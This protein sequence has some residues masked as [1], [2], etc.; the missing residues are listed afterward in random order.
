[1]R[2]PLVVGVVGE[3]MLAFAA[4]FGPPLVLALI[5]GEWNSVRGFAVAMG[6]GL[7]CGTAAHR[8]V[9]AEQ[10]LNLHR[11]EAFAVVSMSWLLISALGAVPFVFDGMSWV[12]AWFESMSGFTT[13]GATVVTDFGA[14]DR[15]FYLWRAMEQ[16]FGGLGVIAL[17]VVVFPQLGVA[18]RQLFFAEASSASGPPLPQVRQA[19]LRIWGLYSALTLLLVV[20]LM[21][22]GMPAFDAVCNALATLS[23]GGFSPN[24]TSIAGYESP[25]AE[26][27]LVPFMAISGMSFSILY[28]ALA[29]R[30]AS[31]LYRDPEWRAYTGILVALGVAVG[32]SVEG[33]SIDGL[34]T[35]LF[36]VASVISSTGFASVDFEQWDA[37]AKALM[38]AAMLVGACA[39]S[40]GGGPK[41]VR[42]I[43]ATRYILQGI[44]RALHPSA[45]LP[46]KYKGNVLPGRVMRSVVTLVV[47]Y[48]LGYVVLAIVLGVQGLGLEEA[49]SVAVAT[50]GNIGPGF[51]QAGP[52]GSYAGF[53]D[54]TK[55][56]LVAAMWIG[57]LEFVAVLVLLHPDVWR[58][59][60]MRDRPPRGP[61]P[62]T[63][64]A[65][66]EAAPPR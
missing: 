36:Q 5:D 17:F 19:S 20:L 16:W 61:R 41:V 44:T 38:L 3:L 63:R 59:V 1:V 23:A 42:I 65:G 2:L 27:V 46:Y 51:G 47:L 32:V 8:Y 62:E 50:L 64:T 57:R 60:R 43:L 4:A 40:A 28:L 9:R 35:G 31:T 22:T 18:G 10:H 56:T 30:S 39:G 11:A 53:S 15:S 21:A 58:S 45:I 25:A 12:D 37:R 7:A 49:F 24:P 13:T 26:W 34:R 66:V 48:L 14:Y 52:M 29:S 54:L 33:P 6:V 55:L